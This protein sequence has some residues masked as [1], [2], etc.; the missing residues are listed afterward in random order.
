[1]RDVVVKT[2]MEDYGNPSS[3]HTKGMEAE[4]YLRES[5]EIIAKTLKVNEKEI[6]FTSGG[7]ESDN[8]ALIGTAMANRRAGKH[9]ITTAIEHAA[10]LQPMLYL[11]EQGF[12]VT[13]LPVDET[14][15]ISLEDLKE[16]LREDT[17]LVSIMYVNNEVGAREPVEEAAEL[18]HRLAPKAWFHTDAIQAYGKYQIRPKKAGI[19]LLSVSGHKIHGPKGSGFLYINEKV[20]KCYGCTY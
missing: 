8:W 13:F 12:E 17:I 9:I 15:L 11:Q 2:M 3:K 20:K 1:M 14:G 7:T 18:V 4:K 6:F 16:A 5:R 10:V 19:D